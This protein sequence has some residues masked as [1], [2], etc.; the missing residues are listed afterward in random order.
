VINSN[1]TPQII[2]GLAAG[3]VDGSAKG[4]F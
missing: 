1:L 2:K 3:D 4:P